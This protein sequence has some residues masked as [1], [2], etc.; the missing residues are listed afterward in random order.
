ME[1]YYLVK[2]AKMPRAIQGPLWG[3]LAAPR[4][5]LATQQIPSPRCGMP[6]RVWVRKTPEVPQQ[7]R[8]VNPLGCPPEVEDNTPQLKKLHTL[9]KLKTDKLITENLSS[10]LKTV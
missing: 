10:Q 9:P 5:P 6:A 7:S 1:I 4:K 2:K 8:L 3:W